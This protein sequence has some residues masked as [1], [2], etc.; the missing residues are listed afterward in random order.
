MNKI[1][2]SLI[3]GCLSRFLVTLFLSISI[4]HFS[5]NLIAGQNASSRAYI[6]FVN[7]EDIFIF[8]D[9]FDGYVFVEARGGVE[10]PAIVEFA[11]FQGLPKSKSRKRDNKC[12]TIE[13]DPDFIKFMTF[14]NGEIGDVKPEMKMEYSYQIKDGKFVFMR[15]ADQSITCNFYFI[16]FFSEKKITSTPLLEYIA[17]KKLERR[18]ERKKKIDERKRQRD[19]DRNRKKNQVVKAIP[20]SIREQV[21]F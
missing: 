16:L 10:Y 9:R 13:T 14:L 21:T 2:H 7:D 11:P 4:I 12:N 6:N 19:D 17:N 15:S 20:S 18:E 1:K 5:P 8:K 3:F